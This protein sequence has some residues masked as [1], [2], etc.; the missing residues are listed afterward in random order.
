MITYYQTIVNARAREAVY[1]L[2]KLRGIT[3]PSLSPIFLKFYSFVNKFF[4]FTF[5]HRKYIIFLIIGVK[6]GCL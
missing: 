3:A 5:K 2:N 4:P 1:P 6:G